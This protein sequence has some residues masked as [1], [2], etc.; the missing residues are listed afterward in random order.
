MR[1]IG[2]AALVTW[3]WTSCGSATSFGTFRGLRAHLDTAGE[4]MSVVAAS[5]DTAGIRWRTC[6]DD[7]SFKCGTLEVPLNVRCLRVL[8]AMPSD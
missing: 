1:A 2:L 8:P 5:G 7:S 6:D 3:V 4:I